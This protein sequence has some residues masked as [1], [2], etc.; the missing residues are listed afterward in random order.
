MTE[1]G[2]PDLDDC[3]GGGGSGGGGLA[4]DG[5]LVIENVE[6]TIDGILVDADLLFLNEPV[7][8]KFSAPPC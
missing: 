8:G 7:T 1:A 3:G 5:L 2:D 6:G 4:I